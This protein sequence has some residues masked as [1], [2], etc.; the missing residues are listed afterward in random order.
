MVFFSMKPQLRL[1]KVI[2]VVQVMSFKASDFTLSNLVK[3]PEWYKIDR[4]HKEMADRSPDITVNRLCDCNQKDKHSL[5]WCW[6]RKKRACFTSVLEMCKSCYSVAV[7]WPAVMYS[8]EI[9]C[10]K[11]SCPE[12]SLEGL[13][14]WKTCH[15]LGLMYLENSA[16]MITVLKHLCDKKELVTDQLIQLITQTN[17]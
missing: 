14:D 9:K 13:K 11:P 8:L 15:T 1:I 5:R 6:T 4:A 10:W 12:K 7:M 16:G 2:I 17:I 3:K